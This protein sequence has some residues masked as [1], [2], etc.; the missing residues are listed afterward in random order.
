[1]VKKSFKQSLNEVRNRQFKRDKIK[2]DVLILHDS[3]IKDEKLLKQANRQIRIH[4]ILKNLWYYLKLFITS[5]IVFYLSLQPYLFTGNY[6][7]TAFTYPFKRLT[8]GQMQQ[9]ILVAQGKY[10]MAAAVFA[11]ALWWILKRPWGNAPYRHK[12]V[13]D[14]V[15]EQYPII[16]KEQAKLQARK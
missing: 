4:L 2:Q 1:M 12:T 5:I 9:M 14:F 7:Q 13:D 11:V 16:K 15:N 3:S 8:N 6:V 10:M